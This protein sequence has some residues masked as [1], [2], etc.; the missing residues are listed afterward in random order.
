MRFYSPALQAQQSKG[1]KRSQHVPE[2]IFASAQRQSVAASSASCAQIF[3]NTC[4]ENNGRASF[5][6]NAIHK[7]G[8]PK[9]HQE[10]KKNNLALLNCYIM[11]T[12]I[13]S[14]P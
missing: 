3:N 7:L 2:T 13:E 6:E 5:L 1:I 4:S 8:L 9:Q 10:L 14:R 12:V 11:R